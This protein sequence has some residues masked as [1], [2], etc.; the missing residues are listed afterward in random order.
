[1]HPEKLRMRMN[2]KQYSAEPMERACGDH[3]QIVTERMQTMNTTIQ[4][5]HPG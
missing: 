2:W 5:E 4:T 3:M 1:M